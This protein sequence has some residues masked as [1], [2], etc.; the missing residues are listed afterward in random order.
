M[1]GYRCARYC[2]LVAEWDGFHGANVFIH[3]R[4]LGRSWFLD[5]GPWYSVSVWTLRII[6]RQAVK[7]MRKEVKR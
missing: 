6:L 2:G 3:G 5:E 4:Y 7:A 1:K